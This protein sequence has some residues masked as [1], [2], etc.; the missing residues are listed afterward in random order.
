MPTE[1]ELKS[2]NEPQHATPPTDGSGVGASDDANNAEARLRKLKADKE[3]EAL[4]LGY[5]T[6]QAALDDIQVKTADITARQAALQE[7]EALLATERERVSGEEMAAIDLRRKAEAF[8]DN[9]VRRGKALMVA[10]RAAAVAV[11]SYH[12]TQESYLHPAY[13]I[14]V[15]TD[16]QVSKAL[17]LA[18]DKLRE[19]VDVATGKSKVT[20]VNRGNLQAVS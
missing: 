9:A 16:G 1:A 13:G 11:E 14:G 12:I 19:A 6:L 18:H 3:Y 5:P 7:G 15:T 8:Y 20:G 4:S 10:I 17:L 2:M